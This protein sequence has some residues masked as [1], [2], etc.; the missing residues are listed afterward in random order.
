M[1]ASIK[2]SG[3]LEIGREADPSTS[4]HSARDDKFLFRRVAEMSGMDFLRCRSPGLAAV[5]FGKS[6]NQV[7]VIDVEGDKYT[8]SP[9]IA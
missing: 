9:V 4:L 1:D 8:G 3:C 7:F 2:K 5:C 6:I